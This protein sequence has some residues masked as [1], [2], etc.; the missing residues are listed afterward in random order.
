MLFVDPFQSIKRVVD[1][2]TVELFSMFNE[3][4][5]MVKEEFNKQNPKLTSSMPRFAG[6]ATWATALKRRVE[7]PMKVSQW[8]GW[9]ALELAQLQYN[10]GVY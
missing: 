1:Q 6:K 2:K 5:N 8:T 10:S 4:L 3:D 7:A 9:L